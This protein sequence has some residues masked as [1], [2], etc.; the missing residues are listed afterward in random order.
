MKLR[1]QSKNPKVSTPYIE[2]PTNVSD[3][4]KEL[5]IDL[6]LDCKCLLSNFDNVAAAEYEVASLFV[7]GLTY[8]EIAAERKVSIETIRSQVS[9]ILS[10]THSSNRTDLIKHVLCT[11]LEA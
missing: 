8:G 1:Y 7:N 5:S 10:K 6:L 3:R 4:W 9:S 2:S 11:N